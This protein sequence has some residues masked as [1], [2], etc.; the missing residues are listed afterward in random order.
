M[1]PLGAE[2]AVLRCDVCGKEPAAGVAAVPGVPVSMAYG[3][4]CLAANAH[5][6]WVL[7]AYTAECGGLRN[8]VAE[9]RGMVDDTLVHLEI[10]PEKFEADVDQAIEDL[11]QA[12]RRGVFSDPPA[13]DLD[14]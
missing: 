10:D 12:E 11:I 13:W 5:P 8:T 1:R 7:V 3:S 6:Y 4:N 9:W 14:L 2:E